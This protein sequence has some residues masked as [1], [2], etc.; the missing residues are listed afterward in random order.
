M[1]ASP[2]PAADQTKGKATA[3]SSLR[4]PSPPSSATVPAMLRKTLARG[5]RA[6]AAQRPFHSSA[7]ARRVVATSPV[8]AQ[9]VHVRA[10]LP[11]S[12]RVRPLTAPPRPQSFGKY[13]LI[14]HEYDAIVV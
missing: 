3:V 4:T 1:T 11:A 13:P 9:E 6:P 7:P 10:P 8:K 2:T 14:E 12:P 5:L